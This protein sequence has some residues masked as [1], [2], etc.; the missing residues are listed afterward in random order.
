MLSFTVKPRGLW[1]PKLTLVKVPSERGYGSNEQAQVS[2]RYPKQTDNL[3]PLQRWRAKSWNSI[4]EWGPPSFREKEI[5]ST[6]SLQS[7]LNKQANRWRTKQRIRRCCKDWHL[8]SC[9]RS[10]WVWASE[11]KP[12]Q[13]V[14]IHFWTVSV[15]AAFCFSSLQFENPHTKRHLDH[16]G[17]WTTFVFTDKHIQ[18]C[19]LLNLN[20]ARYLLLCFINICFIQSS[21]LRQ[22]L[23]LWSFQFFIYEKNW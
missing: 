8:Q 20:C 2:D 15:R 12:N 10:V 21:F 18:K 23:P 9:W 7:T 6:T 22:F 3:W 16:E 13:I 17:I 14:G 4:Q 19:G 1:G 5:H 11:I